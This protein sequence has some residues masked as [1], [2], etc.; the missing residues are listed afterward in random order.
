M[1]TN[2][3][4]VIDANKNPLQPCSPATARNLLDANKAALFR[5]YPTTIIL[6]KEVNPQNLPL[7]EL[8]ID[9]GSK[10]TGI[11]LVEILDGKDV[12]IWA[13]ELEHRG[14]AI[15]QEL[16]KRAAIRRGRRNRNTR[17]RKKRF[18]RHTP[19]GWLAPS[20][21]HRVDTTLTWVKRLIKFAPISSIAVERVKFDLQKLENPNIEGIQYQQGTLAGYTLREAMLEHWGR[22][23]AYC[24]LENVPLE[25]E[26]IHPKSKGGSDRFNNLTLACRNC[27]QSKGNQAVEDFLKDDPK[28]VAQIKA[29]QKKSL[30]DA[31]ACNCTRNKLF[32]TLEELTLPVAAGDGASTKMTRINSGLTKQHWIDA[33]CVSTNQTVVLKTLQPLLVK[34]NGHG[35][36]QFVTMDAYGFP[37]KGYEPKQVRIDW[38]AGDIIRVTR[39]GKPPVIGR[40]KKAGKKLAFIPLGGK[41]TTF[42]TKN[43]K[44]IH[45]SDGYRYSFA[46]IDSDLLQNKLI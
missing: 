39:I 41:E 4:F 43:A 27:N 18:D 3:V 26:H 10:F 5:R 32:K 28:R 35:N 14:A 36:R 12:V 15:S 17:Y 38:K 6:K 30:S 45:R 16:K 19:V 20:L 2:S 22:K 33:S 25:I 29:H 1:T 44:P 46:H 34:C 11:S 24:D 23:C 31:A 13:M 40:V 9:P 7:I 37:R 42:S 21:M 8:R